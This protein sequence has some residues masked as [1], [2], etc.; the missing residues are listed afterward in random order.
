MINLF[1][2]A[3]E[4]LSLSIDRLEY[5]GGETVKGKL[6]VSTNKDSKARNFRFVVEGKEETKVT[7]RE[8]YTDYDSNGNSRSNDRSVTYT[9]SNTFFSKDLSQ[10]LSQGNNP[11]I[12]SSADEDGY[13]L[14]ERKNGFPF[15][16]LL[17]DNSLSSYHGRNAWI[18]YAV[19]ATIDKKLRNDV[20]EKVEFEVT[21]IRGKRYSTTSSISCS[22]RNVKGLFINLDL[23]TDIFEPGDIIKGTLVIG[24]SSLCKH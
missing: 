6:V 21:M 10:F 23:H 19:K 16:F 1:G 12:I 3:T 20:N 4:N 9:A 13:H 7:V 14:T 2:G 8:H 24:G 11:N 15:E 17:S 22:D 5:N 18:R